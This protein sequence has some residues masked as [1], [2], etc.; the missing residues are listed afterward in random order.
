MALFKRQPN[1]KSGRRTAH[2][3]QQTDT[4]ERFEQHVKPFTAGN[5]LSEGNTIFLLH[6]QPVD[7]PQQNVV[8]VEK[9]GLA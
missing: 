7:R 6:V 9:I 4:F 5:R 1:K 8:G 2:R 3:Q